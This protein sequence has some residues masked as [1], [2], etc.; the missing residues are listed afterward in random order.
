MF[1]MLHLFVL[2]A[3]GGVEASIARNRFFFFFSLY[4]ISLL[5]RHC[6]PC[7]LKEI[8]LKDGIAVC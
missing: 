4:F 1:R 8:D 2:I 7:L 5:I 3:N 6:L